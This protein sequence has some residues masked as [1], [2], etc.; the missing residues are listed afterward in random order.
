MELVRALK[1]S[2]YYDVTIAT[3]QNQRLCLKTAL[4][5]MTMPMLRP[6]VEL[7]HACPNQ[8]FMLAEKSSQA[9]NMFL[10]MVS[11]FIDGRKQMAPF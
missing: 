1:I 10:F 2:T 4:T 7:T 8:F 6:K 3:T 9:S 5:V 11:I